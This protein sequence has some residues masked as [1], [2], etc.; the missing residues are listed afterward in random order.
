M[1]LKIRKFLVNRGSICQ[2]FKGF[3]VQFAAAAVGQSIPRT[4]SYYCLSS[5]DVDKSWNQFSS[6]IGNRSQNQAQLMIVHQCLLSVWLNL[7]SLGR[8][9][10]LQC[11]VD[12]QLPVQWL[13]KG[14]GCLKQLPGQCIDSKKP[15]FIFL[16]VN[17]QQGWLF[18]SGL[19]LKVTADFM[20]RVL[21]GRG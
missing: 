18:W 14:G 21:I 12:Q 2:K 13:I 11:L 20:D 6:T 4:A 5:N 15:G 10:V 19:W 17:N 8:C 7:N 16:T 1:S 3:S 9:Q